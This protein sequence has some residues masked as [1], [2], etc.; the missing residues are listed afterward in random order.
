MSLWHV[1]M[2]T[3]YFFKVISLLMSWCLFP[4]YFH[5]RTRGCGLKEL[6][7]RENVSRLL[8]VKTSAGRTHLPCFCDTD[9]TFIMFSCV[10]PFFRITWV[11][12]SWNNLSTQMSPCC[13][14]WMFLKIKAA[15]TDYC[16]KY[17]RSPGQTDFNTSQRTF[18]MFSLFACVLSATQ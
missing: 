10:C 4:V 5:F 11:N 1:M 15:A 9:H 16:H 8:S 7:R 12:C 3:F 18:F 14:M 2:W 6:S 13:Q 17:R